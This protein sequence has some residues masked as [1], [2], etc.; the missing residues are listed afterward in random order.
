MDIFLSAQPTV[1]LLA[2]TLAGPLTDALADALNDICSLQTRQPDLL[3]PDALA[4]GALPDLIGST[5]TCP[6]TRA[7][8]CVWRSSI[9]PAPSACRSSG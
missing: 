7:T 2:E 5:A 8:G 4:Q 6:A 9:T 1:C 3:A